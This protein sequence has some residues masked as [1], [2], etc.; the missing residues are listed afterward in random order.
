MV[1][2]IVVRM[3]RLFV[4]ALMLI[5]SMID[6]VL[7]SPKKE[8]YVLDLLASRDFVVV[9]EADFRKRRIIYERG[10][11]Q[12]KFVKFECRDKVFLYCR[13]FGEKLCCLKKRGC[14][15]ADGLPESDARHSS[16]GRFVT[17]GFGYLCLL[18]TG[19]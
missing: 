2:S 14:K 19:H 5:L 1:L 11:F 10:V 9:V 15:S 8:R 18:S 13:H 6:V 16:R 12:I 4:P 17:V 7:S 3:F